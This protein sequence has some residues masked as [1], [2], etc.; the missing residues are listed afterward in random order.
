[1]ATPL[2]MTSI[3]FW[4]TGISSSTFKASSNAWF[5]RS[6]NSESIS[7]SLSIKRERNWSGHLG[8]HSLNNLTYRDTVKLNIGVETKALELL[9]RHKKIDRGFPSCDTI[10]ASS[11]IPLTATSLL[12][13]SHWIR[14]VM[15]S[16]FSYSEKSW[17]HWMIYPNSDSG[18]N[19]FIIM[20]PSIFHLNQDANSRNLC[21]LTRSGCE[22]RLLHLFHSEDRLQLVFSNCDWFYPLLTQTIQLQLNPEKFEIEISVKHLLAF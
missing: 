3:P 15:K 7:L 5:N 2:W 9:T 8:V 12:F 4:L 6:P 16:A 11:T 1:M 14:I 10:E 22:V 19:E 21:C 20:F 13:N 17:N 18:V